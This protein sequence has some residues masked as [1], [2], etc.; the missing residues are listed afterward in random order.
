MMKM[1]KIDMAQ[2]FAKKDP[3]PIESEN[4]ISEKLISRQDY[5]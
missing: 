3:K 5:S 2:F 1:V 4:F